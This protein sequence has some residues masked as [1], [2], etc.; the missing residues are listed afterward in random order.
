MKLEIIA[1]VVLAVPAV[2]AQINGLPDCAVP[3]LSNDVAISGCRNETDYKCICS[4]VPYLTYAIDCFQKSCTPDQL[5]PAAAVAHAFCQSQG[6]D[7]LTVV[8]PGSSTP[9]KTHIVPPTNMPPTNMPPTHLPPTHLPGTPTEVTTSYSPTANITTPYPTTTTTPY[10][11]TTTTIYGTGSSV[12]VS[13][14]I[15]NPTVVP[16]G[17]NDSAAVKNVA[18]LGAIVMAVAAF[19]AL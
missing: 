6:V 1:F 7:I 15:T 5:E 17:N 12:T 18:G 4:S 2:Y 13:R 8:P 19:F 16:P 11:G 3:C 14:N 10:P 9:T